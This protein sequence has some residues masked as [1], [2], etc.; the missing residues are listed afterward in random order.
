LVIREELVAVVEV[1][2]QLLWDRAELLHLAVVGG[3]VLSLL[4]DLLPPIGLAL[5]QDMIETARLAT[6]FSM[7]VGQRTTHAFQA[8]FKSEAIARP[9]VKRFRDW[10]VVESLATRLW[11]EAKYSEALV[12]KR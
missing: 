3:E 12:C 9:Q 5:V 11:V 8:H 1:G 4:G 7:N 6:P 2:D 10:L